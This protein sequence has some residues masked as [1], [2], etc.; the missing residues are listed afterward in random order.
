[1]SIWRP[2]VARR[3]RYH[4]SA[5]MFR[6]TAVRSRTATRAPVVAVLP[7]GRIADEEDA[8]GARGV[9]DAPLVHRSGVEAVDLGVAE[10]RLRAGDPGARARQ[11]ELQLDGAA[12]PE[13]GG[14]VG[15]DR[16]Q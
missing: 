8:G 11:P 7:A 5:V 16:L 4:C 3:P 6:P 14:A 13:D 9:G 12:F 2:R 1:M 10:P 15:V